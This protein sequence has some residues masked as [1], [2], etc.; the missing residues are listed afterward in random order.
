VN[1]EKSA[2]ENSQSARR[3]HH[4]ADADRL[5]IGAAARVAPRH[6]GGMYAIGSPGD[7]FHLLALTKDRTLCGLSVA[8]IVIDHT[9]DTSDLHLTTIK[10][11]DRELCEDCSRIAAGQ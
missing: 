2:L 9:L 3:Q 11:T 6:G 10:P 1:P 5:V 4:Y 7:E 8:P